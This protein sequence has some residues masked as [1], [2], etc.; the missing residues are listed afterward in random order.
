[1]TAVADQPAVTCPS[2]AD[3]LLAWERG[4]PRAAPLRGVVLLAAL[5]PDVPADRLARMS[6]GERDVHLLQ[7]R[8]RDGRA[9]AAPHP[10]GA[11]KSGG[12]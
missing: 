9:C 11:V 2:A 4:V 8:S 10:A 5:L 3:L 12:A 6:I 1:M 7:A